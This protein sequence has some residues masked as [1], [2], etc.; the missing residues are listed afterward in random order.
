MVAARETLADE[1][2]IRE[3]ANRRVS[4][5]P[6]ASTPQLR[7]TRRSWPRC[8]SGWRTSSCGW[9]R[10]PPIFRARTSRWLPRH[11]AANWIPRWP[12]I[13]SVIA[14]A[15]AS[16]ASE[17][18]AS[19]LAGAL[20]RGDVLCA[21]QRCPADMTCRLRRLAARHVS[22]PEPSSRQRLLCDRASVSSRRTVSARVSPSRL[23][24]SIWAVS[25]GPRRR[26]VGGPI[27]GRPRPR[28]GSGA[29]VSTG[30]SVRPFRNVRSSAAAV[31]WL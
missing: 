11:C 16:L 25:S 22:T 19:A 28:L 5:P 31:V 29:S 1:I 6:A 8:R 10:S 23:A 15:G 20:P 13:G 9:R 30:G 26:V 4:A 27:G 17:V 12:S 21:P 14:V 24:W 7:N 3:G 18:D 2:S